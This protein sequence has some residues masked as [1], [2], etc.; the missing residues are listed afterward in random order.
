MRIAEIKIIRKDPIGA[1]VDQRVYEIRGMPDVIAKAKK[2]GSEYDRE[3]IEM[4]HSAMAH[5]EAFA[6]IYQIH[7]RF[8]LMQKLDTASF[9]NALNIAQ[10]YLKANMAGKSEDTAHFY[11]SQG[12]FAIGLLG[13]VEGYAEGMGKPYST[14]YGIMA[15]SPYAQ[16]TESL[17]ELY[18]DALEALGEEPDFHPG[19]IAYDSL[20][21]LKMI[22]W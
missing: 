7:P 16:L 18:G 8:T 4:L 1:G 19:N 12:K 6:R 13:V 11:D 9:K 10:Q 5:P 20:G 3:E 15:D 14:A 17:Y 2:D 22:D 21:R